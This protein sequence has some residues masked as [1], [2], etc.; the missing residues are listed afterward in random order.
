M[1]NSQKCA[2]LRLNGHLRLHRLRKFNVS[3]NNFLLRATLTTALLAIPATSSST[4]F[5][6]ST[7]GDASSDCE[8]K[9]PCPNGTDEECVS[10]GRAKVQIVL[11]AP[12][13]T[14]QFLCIKQFI[15]RL[16]GECV[17]PTRLVTQTMAQGF[18][19]IK[20]TLVIF[21]SAVHLGQVSTELFGFQ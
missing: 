17:G 4:N 19:T 21:V 12:L 13:Q 14:F 20:T 3:V 6:G 18:C 2:H 8:H 15:S 5:C 9:Q 16:M 1:T 10:K 11:F 7:W